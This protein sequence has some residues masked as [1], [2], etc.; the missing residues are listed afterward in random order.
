[1]TVVDVVLIDCT[2][3]LYPAQLLHRDLA[4]RNVLVDNEMVCKVC[5]FGSARDMAEMRQ[6]ES[7]TQVRA[8][9]QTTNIEPM[10]V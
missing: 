4:T 2:C 5:D 10:L 1:M 9:Q 6:Y 7:R 8:A 3:M